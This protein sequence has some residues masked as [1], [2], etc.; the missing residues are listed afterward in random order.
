MRKR[1][2]SFL[3]LVFAVFSFISCHNDTSGER[4]STLIQAQE[5]ATLDSDVVN[6]VLLAAQNPQPTAAAEKIAKFGAKI[7]KVLYWTTDDKGN[8]VKASGVMLLPVVEDPAIKDLYS[9]PI[10]SDQHGTI[11]L[12][13]EAPSN[14]IP[15]NIQEIVAYLKNPQGTPPQINPETIIAL[16]YTGRLGFVTLMP[17]YIGY[18]VSKDHY[19]PYMIANS[20]AN[21]AIDLINAALDYAE[22]NG[23]AVKRE[24]YLAGYSEGGYATLATAKKIQ[25]TNQR[26]KVKAV[27]PMG[28]TYNLEILALGLLQQENMP[29]PPFIAYV[30]YAYAESYDNITLSDLINPPFDQKIPLYFDKTKDGETIY[31]DMLVTV[32]GIINPPPAY[33]S[34]PSIIPNFKVS[35]LFK[36]TMIQDFLTNENN[37]FRTDLRNNNVDNWIPA[38]PIT[39]VHCEGDNI[40]PYQLSYLTYENFKNH[41]VTT[42]FVNPEELFGTGYLDHPNCAKPAY[43]YLIYS[44]CVNEYGQEKCGTPPWEAENEN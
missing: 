13:T 14:V 25:E 44:L 8:K 19:H 32:C 41:G 29:F 11:F 17:D 27:F 39:F 3:F 1:Y 33:C 30:A 7:Y 28:G 15:K 23:E 31:K 38:F 43:N 34:D 2:F 40:L 18:G 26:F 22:Q 5:V 21:S 4:E 6:T 37:P 10:I 42:E 24:V 35:Y 12:D 36:Q 20:L 9:A 16:S